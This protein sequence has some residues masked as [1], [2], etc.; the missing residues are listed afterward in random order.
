MSALYKIKMENNKLTLDP[1]D[2]KVIQ[3]KKAEQALFKFYGLDAKEHYINLPKQ[4]IKIRVSEIGN[5]EPIV[6]VPGNTGDV[7][8]LSSLL[9]QLDGRR[10]IAI[11]RPGGGLSEGMNHHLIDIRQFAIDTLDTVFEAFNLENA[12]IVA[13]S[14]GAHW[15]VLFA[16][17]RPKRVRR[18]VLLGNPGNIMG[19]KPP[20]MIRLMGKPLFS[21]LILKLMIQ[22]GKSKALN[23]LTTVGHSKA[24]LAKL[25]QQL[26]ESYYYFRLLPHYIVSATSMLENAIPPIDALQLKNL[27]QPTALLLG[28]NDNFASQDLGQKIVSEMPKGTFYSIKDSGHLPWLES[29]E[30]CGQLIR[31]FIDK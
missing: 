3:A 4:A 28:T 24:L 21:K 31:D 19:G 5:G 6:I 8:P 25:P 13:H 7:F 20:F 10:I 30:E 2:P 26:N 22:K 29:P 14:M 18:L 9:A 17:E 23:A 1:K 16:M 12:D 11:N 15:S 27:S